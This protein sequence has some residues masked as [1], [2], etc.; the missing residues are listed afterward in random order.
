MK[1]SHN[2]PGAAAEAHRMAAKATHARALHTLAIPVNAK[3]L[4]R[5]QDL[6]VTMP[7][8]MADARQVEN[9]IA[10]ARAVKGVCK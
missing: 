7:Q 5:L 2:A 4:A 10:A 9:W 3:S 1:S 8:R 6:T